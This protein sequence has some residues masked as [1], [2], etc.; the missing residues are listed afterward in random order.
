MSHDNFDDIRPKDDIPKGFDSKD[1]IDLGLID[2]NAP[3]DS[4]SKEEALKFAETR[5]VPKFFTKLVL[6]LASDEYSSIIS[7]S[8][9]GTAFNI[10]NRDQFMN[11]LLEHY[12]ITSFA[13]FVRQLNMYKFKKLNSTNAFQDCYTHVYFKRGRI[14]LIYNIQRSK[15]NVPKQ[16]LHEATDSFR[17]EVASSN[18]MIRSLSMRVSQLESNMFILVKVIEDM[19]R[20]VA[21]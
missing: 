1:I 3:R 10:Y 5:M 12:K 7:W 13:S 16:M 21:N 18:A 20:A 17:R 2:I 8:S 19:K 9:D 6:I 4:F 15:P 14:D 11:I